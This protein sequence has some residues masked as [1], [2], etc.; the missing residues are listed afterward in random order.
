MLQK[1][2]LFFWCMLLQN[3]FAVSVAE[4]TDTIYVVAFCCR[5]LSMQRMHTD[6]NWLHSVA[7]FCMQHT[8]TEK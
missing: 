8:H 1:M 7:E 5:T 4:H 6:R 2:A 3:K